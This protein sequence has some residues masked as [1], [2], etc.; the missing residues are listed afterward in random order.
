[1]QP[2]AQTPQVSIVVRTKDRPALLRRALRSI[3]AQTF[4]RWEAVIVNDGGD[5]TAVD[6]AIRELPE[7]H[8]Q[9]VSALHS[10]TSRGRWVSANAGVLATSAPFLVLHDDDDTWDPEFLNLAVDYLDTHPERDGIVSRIEIVW[11]EEQDGQLV[12]TDRTMFQGQ[13]S[14]PMLGDELLLNRFVP[15][16]FLYRRSLHEE[17]GLYDDQLPV[18]GDW[19]FNLKVL[20]R[21]PLEYLGDTPY[22]YWHQRR[23]HSGASGNS[24]IAASGDHKR[25]DALVRDQALRRYINEYG[26]G[27]PL[28]LSK[29][30]ETQ[31]RET[32]GRLHKELRADL[33]R[34]LV[35]LR[36][37]IREDLRNS[38]VLI[39]AYAKIRRIFGLSS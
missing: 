34:D 39:R 31:L 26:P 16:G 2:D 17:L 8:R 23:G 12:A 38:S 5:P 9:R 18:V 14:E 35:D 20:T 37:D 10:K 29:F 24:V 32:K 6:L 36:H 1:M 19:D 15:I 3:T 25:F 21:G 22:A 28:Y 11:E 33:R 4:E 13:L 30:I 7:H 27:L